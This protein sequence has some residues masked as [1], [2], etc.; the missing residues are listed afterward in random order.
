VFDQIMKLNKFRIA[1]AILFA[2]SVLPYLAFS[3]FAPD[4]ELITKFFLTLPFQY[5]LLTRN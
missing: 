1:L 4:E 3:V 5:S 2:V